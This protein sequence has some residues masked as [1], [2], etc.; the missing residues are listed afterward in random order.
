[1]ILFRY[2]FSKDIG[3]SSSLISLNTKSMPEGCN[4]HLGTCR[5]S[6]ILFIIFYFVRL[7]IVYK[8]QWLNDTLLTKVYHYYIIQISNKKGGVGMEEVISFVLH[9]I[10]D[11]VENGTYGEHYTIMDREKN[12]ALRRKYYVTD[13]KV[14]DILRHLEKKDFIESRKSNHECFFGWYGLHFW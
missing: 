7:Q 1:M 4:Y 6:G 12:K 9:R 11:I 14:R 2:W 13:S 10:H 3:S 8:I 5:L